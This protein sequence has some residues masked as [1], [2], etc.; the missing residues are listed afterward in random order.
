MHRM[1]SHLV[2][3]I[4]LGTLRASSSVFA[5]SLQGK[6]EVEGKPPEAALVYF[7]EDKDLAPKPQVE[8]S[9]K[10][11]EFTTKLIVGS[12]GSRV[13]LRNA[14]VINHNIYADD[15]EAKAKFDVGLMAPGTITDLQI[16]WDDAVIRSS[17]KIHPGMRA[18]IASISSRYYATLM[19]RPSQQSAEFTIDNVPSGLSKV[20]IWL[21]NV[22]TKEFEIR[23]GESSKVLWEH[24]GKTIGTVTLTRD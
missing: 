4:M 22:P 15:K 21:P 24:D 23:R 11:K 10:D 13:L 1:R 16:G 5:A 2:L 19:F 6:L 12:K 3:F 17:C 8:L 9:Q 20:K 18:W 14:D 7:S